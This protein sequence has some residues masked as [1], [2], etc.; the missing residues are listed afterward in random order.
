M[1]CTCG[2]DIA[3][4]PAEPCLNAMFAEKVM[5][6]KVFQVAP[7][8]WLVEITPSWPESEK[9]KWNAFTAMACPKFSTSISQAMEGVDLLIKTKGIFVHLFYAMNKWQFLISD[10][11]TSGIRQIDDKKELAITRALILWAAKEG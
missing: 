8:T 4:H 7:V 1:K 5:T 9:H 6:W 10:L 3:T 2:K 11:K